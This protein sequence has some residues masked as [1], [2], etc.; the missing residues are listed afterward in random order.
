M[1]T[2]YFKAVVEQME[3][4][5]K[6][7]KRALPKRKADSKRKS[8]KTDYKRVIFKSKIICENCHKKCTHGYRAALPVYSA[9]HKKDIN[10]CLKCRQKH[11]EEFL[12][13]S[14]PS[15]NEKNLEE[16]LRARLAEYDIELTPEKTATGYIRTAFRRSRVNRS[17]HK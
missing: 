4:W 5:E 11:F 15:A 9:I 14:H 7:A 6:I 10:M 13:T 3:I 12:E 16:K 2:P 8:M 1:A 17:L